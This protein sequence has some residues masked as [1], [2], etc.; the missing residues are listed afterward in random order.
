MIWETLYWR[1][2]KSKL[3]NPYDNPMSSSAAQGW[4]WGNGDGRL[5]YPPPECFKS[6]APVIKPPIDS[7]RWEMIRDG[8][9]DYE[10]LTILTKLVSNRS[11]DK[12]IKLLHL[13]AKITS[14]KEHTHN[15][16]DIKEYREKLAQAIEKLSS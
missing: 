5:L 4:D 13:P 9:E 6:N 2:D 3:E 16:A 14:L 10:Y 1:A 15:P 12:Y 8:I 11:G 7:I